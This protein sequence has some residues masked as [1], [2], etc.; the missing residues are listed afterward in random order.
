MQNRNRLSRL[1]KF[2]SSHDSTHLCARAALVT[3]VRKILT[4]RFI[5]CKGAVGKHLAGHF[6]QF[7]ARKLVGARGTQRV[8]APVVDWH[9]MAHSQQPSPRPAINSSLIKVGGSA[10]KIAP[11][12]SSVTGQPHGQLANVL[13]VPNRTARVHIAKQVFVSILVVVYAVE[14]FVSGVCFSPCLFKR[15][16]VL[17][18]IITTRT[19]G[20][21][22][23]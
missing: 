16:H 15:I 13:E 1:C 3:P 23:A 11:T 5:G 19:H 14:W 6:G 21:E 9:C 8:S 18:L 17:H 22:S 12:L 7:E 4:P 20:H 2:N 10:L